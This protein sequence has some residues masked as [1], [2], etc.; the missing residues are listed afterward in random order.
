MSSSKWMNVRIGE[1]IVEIIDGDRGINY[2]SQDEFHSYDYCLFLN[3]SN[4]TTNGFNFDKT[5]Y[6]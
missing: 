4:V 1:S 2:P 5:Q 6:R 3:T